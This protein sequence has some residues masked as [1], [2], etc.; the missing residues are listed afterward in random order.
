MPV[1]GWIAVLWMSVAAVDY[2]LTQV[3]FAP[4]VALFTEAQADYF[5]G[6][7]LWLDALWA[8]GVWSGLAGAFCL[9]AGVR[10]S[11]LLLAVSAL[12]V[13]LLTVGLVLLTD[14]PMV[15]VTGPVG[16]WI[17]LGAS[18][19]HVAFWLHARQMHARGWVP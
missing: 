4:Y 10:L 18:V 8:V 5:L 9:L 2:L 19:V 6:L 1:V 14:P 7:P 15:A 16:L 12:G 17:M 11:A 13:V 3:A